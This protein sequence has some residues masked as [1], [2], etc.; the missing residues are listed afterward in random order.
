MERGLNE[1]PRVAEREQPR[2]LSSSYHQRSQLLPGN[3]TARECSFPLR[4]VLEGINR[5]RPAG[6]PRQDTELE[7]LAD[8]SPEGLAF[9]SQLTLRAAPPQGGM[10]YTSLYGARSSTRPSGS[11]A[12]VPATPGASGLSRFH[13][14][15]RSVTAR[16]TVRHECAR[17]P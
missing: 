15:S 11:L 16:K 3:G 12:D 8:A 1:A 10:V 2:P 17:S 9:S 14:V 7:P 6:Y 13:G 5:S 4:R